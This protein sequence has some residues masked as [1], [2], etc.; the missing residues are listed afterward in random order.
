VNFY[1]NSNGYPSKLVL[2]LPELGARHTGE[3]ITAQILKILKSY[4][5]LNKI[6]YFTLDN[7]SNMDLVMEEISMKLGFEPKSRRIR[8]FGHILNLVAKAIALWP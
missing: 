1:A 8:Y 2:S 6:G 3:N 7:A 5:I 4:K